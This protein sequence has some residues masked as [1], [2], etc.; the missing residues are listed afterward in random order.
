MTLVGA[1]FLTV[2][3]FLVI[4]CYKRLER[5]NKN[6]ENWDVIDWGIVIGFT[7][8]FPIGI[9]FVLIFIGWYVGIFICWLFKQLV[10]TR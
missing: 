1:L 9:I 10:K 8:F 4:Q 3:F 7:V 2:L 6:L 5:I